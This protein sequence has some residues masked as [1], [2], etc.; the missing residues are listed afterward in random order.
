MINP[1]I[2]NVPDIVSIEAMTRRRQK[3]KLNLNMIGYVEVT[4]MPWIEF[5][6]IWT[7]IDTYGSFKVGDIPYYIQAD[8]SGLLNPR[9]LNIGQMLIRERDLDRTDRL[10]ITSIDLHPEAGVEIDNFP[11]MH[12]FSLYSGPVRSAI[13]YNGLTGTLAT[14]RELDYI[15]PRLE[16]QE[17]N[18]DLYPDKQISLLDI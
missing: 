12:S 1:M 6:A 5:D 14:I 9:T 16:R 18:V 13:N 10:F 3:L 4:R 17:I 7:Y 8:S 11:F 15:A 2:K